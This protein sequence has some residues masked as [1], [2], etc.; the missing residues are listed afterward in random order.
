M[1]WTFLAPGQRRPSCPC[2]PSWLEA[3]GVGVRLE[4]LGTEGRAG[5]T[6]RGPPGQAPSQQLH[7]ANTRDP[8]SPFHVSK[9]LVVPVWL[10]AQSLTGVGT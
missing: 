9:E 1:S 8:A 10:R 5:I 6:L 4:H 7:G 2:A 3:H